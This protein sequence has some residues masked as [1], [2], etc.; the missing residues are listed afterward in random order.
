M[1]RACLPLSRKYSPM[2]VAADGN[3]RV[4]GLDAGSHGLAD[5]L[6]V[7]DAG[8]EA[9]DG[10]RVRRVDGALVVDWLTERV[11][12]AAN[13]GLA[14]GHG[15]DLAG[16]L[17]GV[18]FLDLGVVAEEHGSDLVLVEVHGESGDAVGELDEL[19]GHDLVQTVDARDAVAEG[20]DGS[21]L[22]DLDALFE[23]LNLLAKQLCYLIC[24]D[25]C[26][27]FLLLDSYQSLKFSRFASK[28]AT[29]LQASVSGAA[30][31]PEWSRH[32][33]SSRCAR[34]RHP[35]VSH[36]DGRLREP[37]RRRVWRPGPQARHGRRRS[38]GGR[39]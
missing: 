32:T 16:A 29:R 14:D 30:T 8:G 15:H 12:D 9:L 20:D 4:D 10:E 34:R 25:L 6:A 38:R 37:V 27:V 28:R 31:A 36:P 17:D 24:L 1:T 7:D 3:H 39:W 22:I 18:A 21:N 11:D 19:A 35:T 33:R 26:H 5:R 2:A 13:H 23:V